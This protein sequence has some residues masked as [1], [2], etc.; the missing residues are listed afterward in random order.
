M[1]KSLNKL[2]ERW[3]KA[4]FHNGVGIYIKDINMNTKDV[5]EFLDFKKR[6]IIKRDNTSLYIKPYKNPAYRIS[7]NSA[8]VHKSKIIEI[9][10]NPRYYNIINLSDLELN[11]LILDTL[12]HEF[13]HHIL[14][15]MFNFEISHAF[16]MIGDKIRRDDILRKTITPNTRLHSDV[17]TDLGAE[18]WIKEKFTTCDYNELMKMYKLT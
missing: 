2:R 15:E 1:S 4:K 10:L 8:Y 17:V 11:K 9:G 3:F 14:D 5:K 16:D 13:L 7:N 12:E 6:D 18:R